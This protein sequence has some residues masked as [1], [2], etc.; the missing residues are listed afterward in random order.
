MK[1]QWQ[2]PY[3][4]YFQVLQENSNF[5]NKESSSDYD[6]V[7]ISKYGE[8]GFRLCSIACLNPKC[9]ELSLEI[10][11]AKTV[12]SH[13]Q[14][15]VK[16]FTNTIKSWSLMPDSRA[17]PQPDYIPQNIR[18]GYN[19]ACKIAD[20]SPR[21]SAVLARRCLE[22]MIKDFCKIKSSKNLAKMIKEVEEKANTIPGITEELIEAIDRIRTRGN[23]AAHIQQPT[24]ELTD[25]ISKEDAY[26]LIELLEMLFQEWY[27][28]SHKR[29]ERLSKIKKENTKPP[30]KNQKMK[31]ESQ[32][33]SLS[34]SP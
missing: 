16:S 1:Q 6:L 17:K 31:Q 25:S 2:C 28:A 20:L 19:E 10:D 11:L 13:E 33:P 14:F 34:S 21:A 3:C 9:K 32:P 4:G 23:I 30:R 8:I 15:G 12:D 18:E 26:L 22:A 7:S 29:K 5:R 27:I 24:N